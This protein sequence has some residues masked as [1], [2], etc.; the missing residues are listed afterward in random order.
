MLDGNVVSVIGKVVAVS[1]AVE[2]DDTTFRYVAICDQSGAL[3]SF[4]P[5]CALPELAG[6]LQQ[7]A[8]GAFIFLN[9]PECRLCF[10]YSDDGPRGV[11]FDALR[12][13]IEEGG[14]AAR[15]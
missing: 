4:V 15:S 6:F 9:G 5:V 14:L 10:A 1:P 12:G 2:G 3:R 13:F 8:S 7:D 11:D